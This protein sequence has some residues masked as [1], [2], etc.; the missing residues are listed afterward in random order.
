MIK[1]MPMRNKEQED[2]EVEGIIQASR[3]ILVYCLNLFCHT[4]WESLCLSIP[5]E[6]CP[7]TPKQLVL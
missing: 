1:T 3:P 6:A 7:V 4:P 5:S 2:F